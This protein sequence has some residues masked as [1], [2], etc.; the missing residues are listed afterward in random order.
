MI[1]LDNSFNKDACLFDATTLLGARK[2]IVI[3]SDYF[4][5]L[6]TDN[7]K[8]IERAMP[9]LFNEL[10]PWINQ[11]SLFQLY[12]FKNTFERLLNS[13]Y[14]Q[15]PGFCFIFSSTLNAPFP[16]GSIINLAKQDTLNIQGEYYRNHFIGVAK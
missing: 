7:V 5:L 13:H 3:E 14:I 9:L 2:D 12:H 10:A 11:S 15:G 8:T 6:S 4:K 1:I 16:P